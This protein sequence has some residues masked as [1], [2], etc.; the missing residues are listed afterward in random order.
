[1]SQL[2]RD[3]K[4][5]AAMVDAILFMTIMLIASA[6]II[7]SASSFK[8]TDVKFSGLQQYTVDFT[9]TMLA[10][11][12]GGLQYKIATGA[13]VNVS[14]SDKSISQF[15]CDEALIL[16]ENTA[17]NFTNY[18]STIFSAGKSIIRPG[19][20]YAISCDDAIFLSNRISTIS[21]LP[22]DRCASQLIVFAGS[23]S[24]I[25]IIVYVW[26]I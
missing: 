2:H 16:R 25:T 24:S 13:T 17:S 14:G 8:A 9:G 15:L 5:Q 18:E 7:G 26:V 11:E 22:S 20:D 3:R 19:L 1:M 21:D 6:V 4:G 10:M 23:G 12:I